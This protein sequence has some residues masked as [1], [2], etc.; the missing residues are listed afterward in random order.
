M[1]SCLYEGT[2]WHRRQRPVTHQFRYGLSMLYLDLD[3][4]AALARQKLLATSSRWAPVSLRAS[5]YSLRPFEADAPQEQSDPADIGSYLRSAV[6]Q[7]I[8]HATGKRPAGPIRLLCQPRYFGYFFSPLNLYY[9]FDAADRE[10]EW[11]VAEVNNIPWRER[12]WYLL[13]PE[14][15][16]G[17]HSRFEH[18]KEFHVS[19]FMPLAQRYAWQ[20]GVPAERLTVAIDSRDDAMAASGR[21]FSAVMSLRRRELVRG[22]QYGVV[23]RRGFVSAQVVAAIYWQ[24]LLLWWKGCPAYAHPG[25]PAAN[26]VPRLPASP[27]AVPIQLP[28]ARP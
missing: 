13:A 4:M 22:W 12:H 23:A 2:V 19:P 6:E 8:V 20:L 3:E 16:G 26:L 25:S 14:T 10:V 28:V 5:D 9:C 24:A 17:G 21:L 1:H 18:A 11:V 27:A 7:H 15:S